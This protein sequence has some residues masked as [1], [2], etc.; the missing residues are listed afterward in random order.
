MQVL[1]QVLILM[2]RGKILLF[3]FFF[4]THCYHLPRKVPPVISPINIKEKLKTAK[5]LHNH[6]QQQQALLH[7][8]DVVG[9]SPFSDSAD[10]AY[11]LM[12]QIYY[13]NERYK[14]SYK[15]YLSIVKSSTQSPIE[16]NAYLGA[17]KSL[18]QLGRYDESFSLINQ[19]L[20]HPSIDDKNNSN[21]LVEMRELKDRIFDGLGDQVDALENLI[22]L[23]KV[24]P[25]A[26]QRMKYE[27]K[28]VKIV[29]SH[30]NVEELLFVSKKELFA[31]IHPQAHFRLASHYYEERNFFKAQYHTNHISKKNWYLYEKAQRL[32]K[33]MVS[34]NK[35]HTKTI[36]VIL[37]LT[38]KHSRWAR[39][40]LKGLQLSLGIFSELGNPGNSGGAGS[41]GK[42]ASLEKPKSSGKP[43]DAY[44]LAVVDSRN[45]HD[46]ARRAVENL[47]VE[48][49][50]IAIVGGLLTKTATAISAKS[51]ELG[52]PNISLSQKSYLTQVGDYVFRNALTSQILV[53]HLVQNAMVHRGMK[54]FAILYPNDP[55]GIEYAN[56][57]WNEVSARGGMIVSAQSYRPKEA[58][59][60]NVVKR[61]VGTFYLEDRKEEY[62]I[63]LKKWMK[64]QRSRRAR[65][66]PPNDLL[67]PIADFDGVFIPD[68]TRAVGQIAPMLAYHDVKGPVLLGTNLWNHPSLIR[69]GQKYVEGALFVDGL[70]TSDDN[71]KKSE[72]FRRYQKTFGEEPDVF[73]A[74][75]YDVGSLLKKIIDDSEVVSRVGLKENLIH[76]ESFQ[77][78]LG[79]MNMSEQREFRR[80]ILTFEV[81]EG[82]VNKSF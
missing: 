24:H 5:K 19:G 13:K 16:I 34:R 20:K 22:Y 48:N 78:V 21:A 63:R 14:K 49:N 3:S 29:N 64:Q 47:V 39:K 1:M 12:G 25:H 27:L 41:L 74:Q 26:K 9:E 55:Y 6:G 54:R 66:T 58:D 79:T 75:A 17:A 7:L 82:K 52:V 80:P 68:S 56:L 81:V 42:P 40:S 60:N 72:F 38:G 65:L 50:V 70:S 23:S 46:Y 11:M 31:F 32:F 30:L 61:L 71:F 57:F 28:A 8:Q 51:Q 44:T 76:I 62:K 35:V 69:R 2:Q 59:F 10:D 43:G 36:G 53:R 37:P 4:I 73:A 77:G 15:S 18:Y 45:H 67:P 33:Q